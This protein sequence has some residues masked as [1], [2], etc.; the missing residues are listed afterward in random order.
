MS[1]TERT[2]H[3]SDAEVLE[4]LRAQKHVRR[5]PQP[6]VNNTP[7][8]IYILAFIGVLTL[9]CSSSTLGHRL[10]PSHASGFQPRRS[11]NPPCSVLAAGR[12]FCTLLLHWLSRWLGMAHSAAS[13]WVQPW[14]SD[15]RT[16]RSAPRAT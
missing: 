2:Q 10:I 11:G 7:V 14:A 13:G 5:T 9:I 8:W 12:V 16:S 1:D 3:M 15:R 6:S 4:D